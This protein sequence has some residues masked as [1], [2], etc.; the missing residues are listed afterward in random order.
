MNCISQLLK[1]LKSVEYIYSSF[2]D[3][4][5]GADLADMQ[6]ISK[7]NKGILCFLH[8]INSYS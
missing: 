3:N 1:K 5:C 7:W 6:L 4:I 2:R 8:V